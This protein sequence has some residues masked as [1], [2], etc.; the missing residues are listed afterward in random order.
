MNQILS[1]NSPPP[2]RWREGRRLPRS[3]SY[4]QVLEELEDQRK[5]KTAWFIKLVI[6]HEAEPHFFGVED[7]RGN[8]DSEWWVNWTEDPDKAIQ[9]VR[10]E[11]AMMAA[12]GLCPRSKTEAV[13]HEWTGLTK[14]K[15]MEKV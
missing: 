2:K 15:E 1:S 14:S 11:D 9:F 13:K 10:E 8:S 6:E 4:Q 12:I 3:G 5:I 7:V